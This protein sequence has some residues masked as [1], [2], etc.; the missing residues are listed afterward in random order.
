MFTPTI[1]NK[2]SL[3]H[4]YYKIID[5]LEGKVLKEHAAPLSTLTIKSRGWSEAASLH[6]SIYGHL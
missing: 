3:Q 5:K 4:H 6:G 1:Y 2:I